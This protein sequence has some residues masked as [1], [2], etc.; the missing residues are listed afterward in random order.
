M[1]TFLGHLFPA[2]HSFSDTRMLL[3]ICSE[4]VTFNL[5]TFSLSFSQNFS[6]SSRARVHTA[7]QIYHCHFIT[8]AA[9]PEISAFLLNAFSLLV[10]AWHVHYPQSANVASSL[11]RCLVNSILSR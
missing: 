9:E 6:H 3:N 11:D 1:M 2:I 10:K 4:N 7:P 8:L 5:E